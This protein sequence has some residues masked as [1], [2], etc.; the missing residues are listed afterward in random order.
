M[1]KGSWLVNT[2]RGAICDAEAVKEAL[3]S[4]HLAGYGGDVWNKSTIPLKEPKL[5]MAHMSSRLPRTT[6]GARCETRSVRFHVFQRS[7]S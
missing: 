1:K 3:E 2:A 6:R 5:M 4:G 7:S